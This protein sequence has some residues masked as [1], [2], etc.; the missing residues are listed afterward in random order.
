MD[1]AWERAWTLDGI[2]HCFRH[3]RARLDFRSTQAPLISFGLAA[4]RL[5]TMIHMP[6]PFYA[7]PSLR[8]DMISEIRDPPPAL[9]CGE[10]VQLRSETG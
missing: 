8:G 7:L 3:R 9:L 2:D 4:P 6:C 10:P 5:M 1:V